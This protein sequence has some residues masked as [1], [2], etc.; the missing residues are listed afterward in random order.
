MAKGVFIFEIAPLAMSTFE[1]FHMRR[2]GECPGD[3]SQ[4]YHPTTRCVPIGPQRIGNGGQRKQK[5]RCKDRNHN[6]M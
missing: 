6:S 2:G 4:A 5:G 1:V 3:I